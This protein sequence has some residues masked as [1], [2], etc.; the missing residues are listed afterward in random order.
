MNCN[1][2]SNLL[3]AFMDGEL[4]GY[5]HRLIHQHLQRCSQCN[6]EYEE[7][8]QMKRLLAAMRLREPG[9]R[10]AASIV[11]RVQME[12]ADPITVGFG[13]WRVTISGLRGRPQYLSPILGLGAGIA[14]FGLLVWSRS[15]SSRQ[16]DGLRAWG[17]GV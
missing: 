13:K 17:A 2:V 12:S 11:E 7:L 1:K 8:L 9:R 10:S 5:E 6:S 14:F 3:S 15:A 4:M 16:R